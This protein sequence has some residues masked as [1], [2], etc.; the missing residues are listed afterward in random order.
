ML[1][2]IPEF[3]ARKSAI[4]GNHEKGLSIAPEDILSQPY[5]GYCCQHIAENMKTKF[6]LGVLQDAF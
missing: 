6:G 5:R 3:K 2:S 4:I 1:R